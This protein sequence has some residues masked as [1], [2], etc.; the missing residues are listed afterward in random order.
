MMTMRRDRKI[1]P[2]IIACFATLAL[3]PVVR[4]QEPSPPVPS[5]V[6]SGEAT[7]S[8]PPDV[9]YLTLSVESRARSPRDAQRLNAEATDG[10]QKQLAAA[11]IAKDALRTQGLWLEQEY[12]TANNRRTPRGFVA[13]NTLQVRIDDV[14]RA[15]ELADTVVQ[16]GATSISGIRFDLKDRGSV[17]REALR[18]AVEEARHRA[19]A[20]AAGAG[21][22]IDRI[23][24]I[25][26][27][28]PDVIVPQRMLAMR[29]D[30]SQPS[31]AVEPG[32]IDVRARVTLTV[33]MK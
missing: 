8:R 12:D 13:R 6:T 28:R 14:P 1:V 11:G 4:A 3:H 24:K 22:A 18:L 19:E 23:L 30:A 7:V 15:G 20:A 32:M 26:D 2:V 9:A 27:Q 17:E 5:I 25:E 10:V 21:R 33:S 16:G 31:T 29:A